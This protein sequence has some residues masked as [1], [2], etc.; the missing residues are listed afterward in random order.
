MF[1][2]LQI[3]RFIP[4]CCNPHKFLPEVVVEVLGD[5]CLLELLGVLGHPVEHLLLVLLC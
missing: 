1:K 4:G 3:Y 2:D 5:L